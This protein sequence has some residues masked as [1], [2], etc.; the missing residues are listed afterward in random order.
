MG[1]GPLERGR[2]S[3][4][5]DRTATCRRGIVEQSRGRPRRSDRE[6][7]ARPGESA[8]Q[9][10]PR[11]RSRLPTRREVGSCP[12]GPLRPGRT[13]AGMAGAAG[14]SP[15]QQALRTGRRD[16]RGRLTSGKEGEGAQLSCLKPSRLESRRFGD[17]R[18]RGT[19]APSPLSR[20]VSG[21]KYETSAGRLSLLRSKGT[22]RGSPSNPR[23]TS[24]LGELGPAVAPR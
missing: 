12:A 13:R 22:A 9:S 16:R 1:A 15:T 17:S 3:S 14:K 2:P 20:T 18:I 4:A 19:L 7:P 8:G 24:R 23:L 11:P 21:T 6:G 10:V 5:P